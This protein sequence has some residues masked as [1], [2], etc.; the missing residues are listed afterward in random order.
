MPWSR[1]ASRTL[2]V[3]SM[4]DLLE[5]WGKL[6][7][8]VAY[9][10]SGSNCLEVAHGLQLLLHTRI[11]SLQERRLAEQ[12]V[13]MSPLEL[14]V[15]LLVEVVVEECFEDA[16]ESLELDAGRSPTWFLAV[17]KWVSHCLC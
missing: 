3:L 13:L 4:L 14:E 15:V 11:L 5:H 6:M 1:K 10:R 9:S 2:E 12:A 17:P 8:V 7:A 16:N